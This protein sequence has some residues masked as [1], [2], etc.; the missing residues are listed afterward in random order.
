MWQEM[1]E[2]IA[3]RIL[4]LLETEEYGD[5]STVAK[6]QYALLVL[7]DESEKFILLSILFGFFYDVR[8]FY[9]AFLALGSLRI[10]MGGS[11]RQT[12]LGCLLSSLINFGLILCLSDFLTVPVLAAGGLATLLVLEVVFWIPLASPQ[13]LHRTAQQR[14]KIQKKALV[15][16]AVWG[17]LFPFLPAEAGNIVFWALAFQAS[18]VMVVVLYRSARNTAITQ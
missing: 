11:H 1:N 17:C 8:K 16:L 10:F 12:K 5:S 7:L 4:G 2:R 3:H 18:E 6:V 13:Q 14:R 15:S 9:L